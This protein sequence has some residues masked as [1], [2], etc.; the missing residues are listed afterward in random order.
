MISFETALFF[1][2]VIQIR[3]FFVVQIQH[4]ETWSSKWKM[5]NGRINLVEND[6]SSVDLRHKAW[7]GGIYV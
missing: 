1:Y 6:L 4:H 5:Q 2:F 3:F 7:V